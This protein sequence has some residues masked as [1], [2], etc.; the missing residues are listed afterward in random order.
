MNPN[1]VS[2]VPDSRDTPHDVGRRRFIA[3]GS[4]MVGFTLLPAAASRALA[5]ATTT[6][7]GTFTASAPDLPGSLKSS[8]M[9]DAWIRIDA[10]GHVTVFTGKAELGTG[11]RTAFI[12]IA[13]EELD[14]APSAIT[15]LTADTAATPN[16]GYTA[17]SHSVADS[18]TA[19]AHAAAQVRSLLLAASAAKLNVDVATLTVKDGAIHA[20]DG[21]RM[22]FGDA[23]SGV[24][25]HQQASTRS[26]AEGSAHVHDNRPADA[27]RRHSG[28]GHRR[29]E[30][31][32]G[33]AFAEHGACAC[34]APA[35]LWR[36]ARVGGCLAGTGYAGRDQD[37]ARR[38]LSGRGRRRRMARNPRDACI[39][40]GSTME[41]GT[42]VA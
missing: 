24:D 20:A 26:A 2:N 42:A 28:K 10:Q 34:R 36:D 13:A 6:E 37:C 23:V 32:A 9:L 16:E 29:R 14:V 33:H 7:A 21:R 15:L 35:G 25:L 31:C 40:R 3:A 19:I 41:R 4:V 22:S 17:G 18:G 12:Q 5:Q 38:Q 27:A 39:V 30:L 11:I 1:T 8:P